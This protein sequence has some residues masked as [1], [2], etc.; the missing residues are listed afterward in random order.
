MFRLRVVLPIGVQQPRS[1]GTFF[2]Y[3]FG[4]M[5]IVIFTTCGGISVILAVTAPKLGYSMPST[6]VMH[7]PVFQCFTC[8]FFSKRKVMF[9]ASKPTYFLLKEKQQRAVY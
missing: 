8:L 2:I 6:T 3:I 5:I 7:K 9:Y 4:G 1:S